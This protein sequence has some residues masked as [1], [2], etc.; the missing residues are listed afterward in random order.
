MCW[1]SRVHGNDLVVGGVIRGASSHTK[2]IFVG[3]LQGFV[4]QNISS[5]LKLVSSIRAIGPQRPIYV[6]F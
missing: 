1:S 5:R 4:D 3:H 2:E 6:R